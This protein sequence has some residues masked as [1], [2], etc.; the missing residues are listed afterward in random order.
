[1]RR[2]IKHLL[3]PLLS[4]ALLLSLEGCVVHEFPKEDTPVGIDLE[5]KFNTAFLPFKEVTTH[6][7]R[8]P[9]PLPA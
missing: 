2:V 9:Q 7:S 6:S 1:M 8:R 3:L 4:A 5:F